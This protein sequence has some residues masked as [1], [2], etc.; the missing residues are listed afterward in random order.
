MSP[1]LLFH[2]ANVVPMTGRRERA[3]A[4]AVDEGRIVAIGTDVDL[5][6][7]G[8]LARQTVDLNG[9]TVLPGL[10]DTH[11]HLVRT[12]LSMLGP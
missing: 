9:A 1:E 8:P 3:G 12:G 2:N 4:F 6:P 11:V 5:N 7:M 10:I